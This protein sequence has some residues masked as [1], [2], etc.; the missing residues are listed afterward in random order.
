MYRV[1]WFDAGW[2]C[3]EL[4]ATQLSALANCDYLRGR[5]L[6]VM[7]IERPF[8]PML[9]NLILAAYGPG[10]SSLTGLMAFARKTDPSVSRS[11]CDGMH[12]L[13]FSDGS[14]LGII[15]KRSCKTTPKSNQLWAM[16]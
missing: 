6:S 9:A 7:P 8:E 10:P 16:K 4:D 12:F 3:A 1:F 5:W 14:I 2:Q 11:E 15:Y 13:H